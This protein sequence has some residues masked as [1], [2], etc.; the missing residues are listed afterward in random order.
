MV[1]L[2]VVFMSFAFLGVWAFGEGEFWLAL[3]KVIAILAFF[4]CSILISTGVIGGQNIRF[5]YYQDPL[6]ME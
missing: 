2:R 4:L 1:A 5:K 6:Q 3:V